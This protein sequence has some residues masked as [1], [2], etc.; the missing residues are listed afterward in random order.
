[1]FGYYGGLVSSIE[2]GSIDDLQMGIGASQKLV[3]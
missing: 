1:V 3:D 2:I